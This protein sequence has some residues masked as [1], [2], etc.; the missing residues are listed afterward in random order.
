MSYKCDKCDSMRLAGGYDCP[1]PNC[2]S[3]HN[4]WSMI[5]A[6]IIVLIVVGG[7]AF[8]LVML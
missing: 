5:I 1:N 4:L 2:P 6:L 3:N 7:T 8:S